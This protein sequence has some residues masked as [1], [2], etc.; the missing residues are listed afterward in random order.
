VG[1]LI[2]AMRSF[3]DEAD[4][5]E[6]CCFALFTLA[7][8]CGEECRDVI[9]SFG[10][11]EAVLHAL[12]RHPQVPMIQAQGCIALRCLGRGS[13]ENR[14]RMACFGGRVEQLEAPP[15]LSEEPAP[16]EG[17]RGKDVDIFSI[18]WKLADLHPELR[19]EGEFGAFADRR[20]LE[21]GEGALEEE[22]S[23][24]Y[25]A[26]VEDEWEDEGE[27]EG[28]EEGEQEEEQEEDMYAE[29]QEE[30]RVVEMAEGM[31][32]LFRSLR[33]YPSHATLHTCC[34]FLLQNLAVD[35]DRFQAKIAGLEG[36]RLVMAALREHAE[37]PELQVEGYQLLQ[38]LIGRPLPA[39]LSG[40]I[41]TTV[42][43][44]LVEMVLATLRLH[45]EDAAIQVIGAILLRSLILGGRLS[46]GDHG[47]ASKLG[48]TVCA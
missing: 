38:N 13:T 43:D 4:L 47:L 39:G 15:P 28:E 33:T 27:E 42:A 10:G 35:D 25:M 18:W 22:A 7:D 9:A 1:L 6:K 29:E 45:Q 5:Q 8:N 17:P 46:A 34:W 2:T 11:V 41:L 12:L 37:V 32:V 14:W 44:G 48:G 40:S 36:A 24:S 26:G 3:P 19:W 23:R 31:E 21:E 30:V 20:V 16:A